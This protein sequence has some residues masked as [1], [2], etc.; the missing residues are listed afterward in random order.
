MRI[1]GGKARGIPLKAPKG[2]STR[3][4]TD[5]LREAIF[6]SLGPSIEDCKVADLFAGTGSYG[7]EAISRG[8]H[9]A[10]FF[11]TNRSAL[12]CLRENVR[13][14]LR[15]CNM[16]AES[17]KVVERDIFSLE[18][19]SPAYDLIFLD[20]P[21]EMI[22]RDLMRIFEKGVGPIA[23]DGARAILELPGNIEPQIDGWELT[24]R[25]GKAGKDKPTAAIFRRKH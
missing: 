19:N 5:R 3:P 11:E 18:S 6:S 15:S 1:T 7:L 10:T 14:T 4:A 24:R 9:A 17:V 2:D 8:A 12:A 20:P 22:E 16:N 21:Y 23:I 25:I 13:A